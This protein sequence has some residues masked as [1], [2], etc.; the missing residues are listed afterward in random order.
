MKRMASFLLTIALILGTLS[1]TAFAA[2]EKKV[3]T[4]IGHIE[5]ISSVTIAGSSATLTV[6]YSFAGDLDLSNGLALQYDSERYTSVVASFPSGTAA[7]VGGDP[8]LMRVTYQKQN[9]ADS[10]TADYNIRVVRQ[11]ATAP[12]FTGTIT[13]VLSE[14][15]NITFTAADFTSQYVQNN[16]AELESIVISGRNPSFGTLKVGTSNYNFGEAIS[17]SSLAELT[18]VTTDAG[19]A[20]FTVKAYAEGDTVHPIGS[21]TLTIT[22]ASGSA[23]PDVISC[24]K[25]QGEPVTFSA[26][27]F[28]STCEK[29]TGQTLSYVTFTLPAASDGTLYFEYQSSSISSPVTSDAGYYVGSTPS[30]SEVTF[31]PV[32]DFLGTAIVAYTGYTTAGTSYSGTIQITYGED[33]SVDS[34]SKHFRDVGTDMSWASEAIDYLFEQG[35]ISGQKP[36]YYN[37]N[38]SISRG[39]FTLMLCRAFQLSADSTGNFSDVDVNSHYYDAIST[40]KALGIAKGAHG[41][42]N[43]NSALSRQDAMLMLSRALDAAGIS[44]PDGSSQDLSQFSDGKQISD[45]AVDAVAAL[46]KAN[47][48]QGY[49][50]KFMPHSNISRAGIAV[51]LYRILTMQGNE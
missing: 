22:I 4:A 25:K 17:L 27:Q 2:N 31:V 14:P 16:G 36:G 24:S 9:D 32:D 21:V 30:L 6:P 3:L 51:I 7:T 29:L 37:P 18:F 41:K 48:I 45:Y 42:F 19:K 5:A 10:Y 43:P 20:S 50:D 39:D 13:K 40:A 26:D 12:T 44:I 34:G 35:I 15:G 46:V 8:V 38:A 47:I 28:D 23:A 33:D 11:A 49:G 1:S